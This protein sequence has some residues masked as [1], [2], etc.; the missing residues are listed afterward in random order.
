MN[1]VIR[2]INE[3]EDQEQDTIS[4]APNCQYYD[5]NEFRSAKFDP[6][7]YFSILHLNISSVEAHISELKFILTLLDFKFDI[8][9]LCESKLRK[10]Q[11]SAIDIGIEGY[12]EPLS[13]PC[14]SQKGGVLLYIS[15]HLSFKMRDD[16]KIYKAKELESVFVEIVNDKL[17][18][19]IIG[20]IYRHPCMDADEFNKKFL[21]DL[22]YK[23]LQEK[24]KSIYICGDFNLNLLSVDHSPTTDFFDICSSSLLLPTIH[25]PTK[26]NKKTDTLIDNILTNKYNHDMIS[27]N[28]LVG[29][30]DHLP[31]FLLVPQ[32]K[33]NRLP[34]RHNFYKQSWTNFNKESQDNFIMDVINLDLNNSIQSN[35]VEES[36][37]KLYTP[38]EELLTIYAPPRKVTNTNSNVQTQM[39]TM[40]YKGLCST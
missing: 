33:Y 12:H 34:K 3:L 20:L 37:S 32:K 2:N 27:G 26:I 22:S 4:S 10:N 1:Q 13:V 21:L 11:V 7:K 19:D 35:N 30:S 9:A 31:S 16:L 24:K 15:Q 38:L 40:D 8:L 23:L 17:S 18:N 39:Q 5:Q 14:E 6:K 28:I 29:I 25:I 36:F